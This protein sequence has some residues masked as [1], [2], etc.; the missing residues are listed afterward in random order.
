MHGSLSLCD[1]NPKG[2]E[3]GGNGGRQRGG[4]PW[5]SYGRS[6]WPEWRPLFPRMQPPAIAARASHACAAP[7]LFPLSFLFALYAKPVEDSR[8]RV[9]V[10]PLLFSTLMSVSLALHGAS[11]AWISYRDLVYGLLA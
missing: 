11:H 8:R 1:E 7:F 2:C 6:P 9:W 10:V 5:G 4:V 3:G